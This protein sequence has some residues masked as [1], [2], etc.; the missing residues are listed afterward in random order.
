MAHGPKQASER[1]E[2]DITLRLPD[3]PKW[4]HS[5]VRNFIGNLTEQAVTQLHAILTN[6]MPQHGKVVEF[7]R[8]I[9]QVRPDGSERVRSDMALWMARNIETASLLVQHRLRILDRGGTISFRPKGSTEQGPPRAG[10]TTAHIPTAGNHE[11]Q[12]EYTL[13]TLPNIG[14]RIAS[15][16]A[17]EKLQVL[18]A[19]AQ[20]APGGNDRLLNQALERCG[21]PRGIYFD[22][23]SRRRKLQREAEG[24]SPVERPQS[25]PPQPSFESIA[26][27]K[28]TPPMATAEVRPMHH[29]PQ[30]PPPVGG[31][32][33]P[34]PENADKAEEL[35]ADLKS[36]LDAAPRLGRKRRIDD[37]TKR[38]ALELY[39]L[40]L[41]RNV[42]AAA[43]TIANRVGMVP[44][45][46]TTWSQKLGMERLSD[47]ERTE[48]EWLEADFHYGSDEGG[49][50]YATQEQMRQGVRLNHL[51]ERAL[52]FARKRHFFKNRQ[53]SG[54]KLK[55]WKEKVGEQTQ[56][57]LVPPAAP[58][59]PPGGDEAK[60][61]AADR[62]GPPET[63]L[64]GEA[65]P[66]ARELVAEGQHA[67]KAVE[68]LPMSGSHDIRDLL[69][70]LMEQNRLLAEQN[71]LLTRMQ[72]AAVP[73]IANQQATTVTP[74]NPGLPG[75][76]VFNFVINYPTAP[77]ATPAP[78]SAFES[79][80]KE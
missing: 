17:R 29:E 35:F 28:Y 39:A 68:A 46:F 44:A 33:Q 58:A 73:T 77:G 24:V 64:A 69:V 56:P 21:I 11:T 37:E 41:E 38:V 72:P 76:M 51:Y 16:T 10:A 49:R 78:A 74:G 13:D 9:E 7:D 63:S 42:P 43:E 60:D 40:L 8:F 2:Y 80:K 79:G 48:L 19:I 1:D 20:V 30:P 70:A 22:W 27:R 14:D 3:I 54:A 26:R 25:K 31:G 62:A 12:R 66:P 71:Q 75:G 65:Q 4:V 32:V 18:A 67:T 23:L 52:A 5:P 45:L 50:R 6:T 57:F 53:V 61:P 36:R 59:G 55:Q 15:M 34:A 47:Q